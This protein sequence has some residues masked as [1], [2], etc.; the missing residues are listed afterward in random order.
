MFEKQCAKQIAKTYKLEHNRYQLL[1]TIFIG[2]WSS[3]MIL[4]LGARGPC[5]N[6]RLVP[7]RDN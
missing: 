3:G 7:N 6:T 1:T 4:A 2:Q 5:F